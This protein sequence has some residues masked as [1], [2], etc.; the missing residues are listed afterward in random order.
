MKHFI[1]FGDYKNDIYPFREDFKIFSFVEASSPYEAFKKWKEDV[2]DD[3]SLLE[4][5]VTIV[6]ISDKKYYF[7]LKEN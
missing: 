4:D 6:E 5:I 1:I 3:I 7:N 2:K